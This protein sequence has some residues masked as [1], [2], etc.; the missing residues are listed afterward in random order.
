MNTIER[1]ESERGREKEREKEKERRNEVSIRSIPWSIVIP[2]L[3]PLRAFHFE[4]Y[5]SYGSHLPLSF[6]YLRPSSP[7]PFIVPA[8]FFPLVVSSFVLPTHSHDPSYPK[9][10]RQMMICGRSGFIDI[11]L[12]PYNLNPPSQTLQPMTIVSP[13]EKSQNNLPFLFCPPSEG[14]PF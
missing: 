2:P 3:I 7:S 12:S 11:A 4:L 6:F 10:R 13:P 9:P 14:T 8:L 1:P 5:L